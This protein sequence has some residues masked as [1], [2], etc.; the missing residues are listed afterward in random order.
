MKTDS[1]FYQLFQTFP[2]C[3]FELLNLPE[4]T[5]NE[6][7]F[8]SVEIK[9][10][11]FRI[12]GVFLPDDEDK[13]IYFVEVQFQK[14]EQFYSRFFSEIF[15]YLHQTKLSNNWQGVVIYPNRKVE[16]SNTSRYQELLNSDRVKRFYLNELDNIES[17]GLK[18]L[19]LIISPQKE[20]IE[21]G[22]GL[23]QQVKQE[24]NDTKQK[25]NILQLIE[26]ILV[27]KLPLI[28]RQEIEKMFSL[29][30]LRETKVYQEALEEGIEQGRQ[31]G[32]LAAKIA[33]IPRLV[34]LGL[35]VEQ[36]AQALDLDIEQV[37][38][39]VKSN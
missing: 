31:Q 25:E 39:S 11:A 14:D 32:E 12:D 26:T 4:N 30:D 6:Y 20:A 5:V 19:K 21:Q 13:L 3:F 27:Y 38:K 29:S 33:S 36:I 8:S 2:R 37:R 18:T 7:E 28:S 34:A 9:Q 16:T 10:L 24:F 22:K 35:S 17:I 1:I 23:I 15:L